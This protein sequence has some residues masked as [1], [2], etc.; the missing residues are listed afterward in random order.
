MPLLM[1]A[2]TELKGEHSSMMA[3]D[4]IVSSESLQTLACTSEQRWYVASGFHGYS[5]QGASRPDPAPP[6]ALPLLTSG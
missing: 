5:T 3:P 4:Y 1:Q 6:S 2:T